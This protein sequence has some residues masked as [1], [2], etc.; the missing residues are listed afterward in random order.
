M[1]EELNNPI[2]LSTDWGEDVITHFAY[3]FEFELSKKRGKVTKIFGKLAQSGD[4]IEYPDQSLIQKRKDFY[5]DS[6][7]VAD[8]LAANSGGKKK[9]QF[10]TDDL[11][12]KVKSKDSQ[13]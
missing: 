9:N 7:D 5:L 10:R 1:I 8:L 13:A 11:I 3:S 2:T 4:F 6:A 12:N